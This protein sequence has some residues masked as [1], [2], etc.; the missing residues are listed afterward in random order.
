MAKKEKEDLFEK[1]TRYSKIIR[2]VELKDGNRYD[3]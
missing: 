2:S 1:E 3:S